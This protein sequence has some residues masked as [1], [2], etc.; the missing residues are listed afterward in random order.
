MSPQETSSALGKNQVVVIDV[1][2]PAEFTAANIEG[3][4]N[5]PLDK[6][7]EDPFITDLDAK[8][9]VVL[10]CSAGKRAAQAKTQ[11]AS[12][13]LENTEIMAGGMEAWQAAE[14]ACNTGEE[15]M[16]LD[17]QMRIAAGFMIIVGTMLGVFAHPGFFAI[18]MVVGLGLIYSGVTDT[19]AM[20]NLLAKMPWNNNCPKAC[21]IIKALTK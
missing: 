20:A 15:I 5:V 17:C 21:K 10:I 14:L 9:K 18:T 2:T 7:M 8:Q 13:G 16:S 3:A 1:R 4:K 6:L 12:I 19:C 11:L